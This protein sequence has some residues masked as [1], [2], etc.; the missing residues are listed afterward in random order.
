M[1]DRDETAKKE[2]ICGS[3]GDGAWV[4]KA[5]KGRKTKPKAGLKE[6]RAIDNIRF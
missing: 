3:H 5:R 4:A 2:E 6:T 1:A